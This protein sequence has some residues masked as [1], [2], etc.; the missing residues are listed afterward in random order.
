MGK[1]TVGKLSSFQYDEDAV[2]SFSTRVAAYKWHI[3]KKDDSQTSHVV[4]G[5]G[6]S[7]CQRYS[8]RGQTGDVGKLQI[9]AWKSVISMGKWKGQIRETGFNKIRVSL[10]SCHILSP[11]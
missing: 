6:A 7:F 8:W 4:S 3:I 10:D 2:Y 5:G 11:I 1:Q 9:F